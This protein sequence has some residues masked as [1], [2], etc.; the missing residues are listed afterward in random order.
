MGV[1]SYLCAMAD[2]HCGFRSVTAGSGA[3]QERH[4]HPANSIRAKHGTLF[5]ADYRGEQYVSGAGDSKNKP[6]SWRAVTAGS[7]VED[8]S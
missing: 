7:E 1:R 8:Q 5:S 4:T 3:H 2:F 6:S